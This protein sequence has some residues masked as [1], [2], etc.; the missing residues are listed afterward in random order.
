MNGERQETNVKASGAASTV[1]PWEAPSIHLD[2]T[3]LEAKVLVLARARFEKHRA[4]VVDQFFADTCR[5]LKGEHRAM[6]SMAIDGLLRK[7]VLVPNKTI[8]REGILANPTRKAVFAWIAFEPGIHFSRLRGLLKKDSKSIAVHVGMLKQFGFIR[9]ADFDN[10]TVY[11]EASLEP[12]FDRLYYYLHKRH[13]PSI[14]QA[15]TEHP[16]ISFDDLCAVLH[17]DISGNALLRKVNV[18]V[19]Q[20]FLTAMRDASRIIALRVHARYEATIKEFI[21]RAKQLSTPGCK[22]GSEDES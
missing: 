9:S 7:R 19:E 20:G 2:L 3:P 12:S 11:F 4:L 5:A 22:D 21:A 18:L 16:N 17:L 1:A 13:A 8:D 15:I 10:N 14:F 6:V